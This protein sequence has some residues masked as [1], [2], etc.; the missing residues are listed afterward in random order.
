MN[1]THCWDVVSE[2][3]TMFEKEVICWQVSWILRFLRFGQPILSS[4]HQAYTNKNF[5]HRSSCHTGLRVDETLP[6]HCSLLLDKSLFCF[7]TACRSIYGSLRFHPCNVLMINCCWNWQNTDIYGPVASLDPSTEE[8]T[9]LQVSSSKYLHLSGPTATEQ[10]MMTSVEQNNLGEESDAMLSYPYDIHC[11]CAVINLK[12]ADI[13]PS[14]IRPTCIW[15]Y[16]WHCYEVPSVK[17][18]HWHK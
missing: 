8:V 18:F 6:K 14:C 17:V 4:K 16:Q 5:I 13:I 1:Y 2:L 10:S 7:L 9:I 15:P 12:I 3:W 11:D